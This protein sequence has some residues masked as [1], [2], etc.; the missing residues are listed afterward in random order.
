[1][2]ASAG[3]T[4]E[5]RALNAPLAA[6]LLVGRVPF[7][8][9]WVVLGCVWCAGF[10]RQG[11][12][13][14]TLSVFFA[15]MMAEFGWTSAEISGAVALGG[16]LAAFATPML[17]PVL[18][19]RGARLILC[20]A[21][22]TTGVAALLLSQVG[23]LLQF[24]LLFCIARMNFAGP[25]DLGIYG[26]VSNWFVARRR[27]ATA[28]ATS[29]HTAGMIAMPLL[30][31][32]AVAGGSFL[33][34]EGWRAGWAAVGAAVLAL[35]V[36]IWLLTVRRPE[37]VGL[38]PDRAAGGAAAG[39]APEPRFTR[40]QALRTPTF[41]CLAA[42]TMLVFP[43]QAGVSLHQA[44]HM[45]ERGI[46]PALAAAAVSSFGLAVGIGGFAVGFLPRQVPVGAALALPAVLLSASAALMTTVTAPAMG[47]AA[48]MLFG[49]GFG[50]VVTLLPV[51]WADSFGRTSFGAI[52]GVALTLQVLAQAGGPMLSGLLHDITGDYVASLASFSGF[53][54]LAVVVALLLRRPKPAAEAAE[55]GPAPARVA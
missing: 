9:G 17:G 20:L 52:R 26:A 16:L 31:A 22:G 32:W 29:G 25:F 40:A 47:F 35:G 11:P 15:P 48:A 2:G 8:Y 55:D 41:W 43:V 4:A 36:P 6:R 5:G 34:L 12:A 37:D 50:G 27:L 39:G 24:Y 42:F 38:L 14:A 18:D 21:V 51:A 1:M 13:V 54:G 10:A 7:H 33:G 19:R 46:D 44:P 45:I 3:M 49:L 53:A 28:I 23:S 30:V